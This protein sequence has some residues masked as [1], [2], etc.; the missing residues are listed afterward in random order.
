MT[1]YCIFYVGSIGTTMIHNIQIH[2]PD[3]KKKI[4]IY[5]FTHMQI[6]L[7]VMI[8]NKSTQMPLKLIYKESNIEF[9]KAGRLK[10]PFTEFLVASGM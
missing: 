6:F 8:L 9:I 7:Y 2:T 1:P 4:Y 3:P 10:P 5:K